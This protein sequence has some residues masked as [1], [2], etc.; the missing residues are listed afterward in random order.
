MERADLTLWASESLSSCLGNLSSLFYLPCS[1][2]FCTSHSPGCVCLTQSF[3]LISVSWLSFLALALTQR[4]VT[5]SFLFSDNGR[6]RT[7]LDLSEDILRPHKQ[8]QKASG[9]PPSLPPSIAPSS[10]LAVKDVCLL[11]RE[12]PSSYLDLHRHR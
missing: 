12:G 1:F 5:C 7:L 8:G 6:S 3:P 2:F 4:F 9:L 11:G 10:N